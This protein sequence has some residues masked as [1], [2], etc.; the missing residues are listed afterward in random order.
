MDT[1]V[2]EWGV[3]PKSKVFLEA[4][5]ECYNIIHYNTLTPSPTGTVESF[6]A[7]IGEHSF[8]IDFGHGSLSDTFSVEPGYGWEVVGDNFIVVAEGAQALVKVC[9]MLLG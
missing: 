1:D 6:S 7:P 2:V 5:G 4:D 9:Q 8:T 3:D